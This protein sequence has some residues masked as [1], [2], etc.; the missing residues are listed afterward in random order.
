[1]IITITTLIH[2]SDYRTYRE[3]TKG[4]FCCNKMKEQYDSYFRI[5]SELNILVSGSYNEEEEMVINFCPFCGEKIQIKKGKTL[6]VI[7]ARKKVEVPQIV[8]EYVEVKDDS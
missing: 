7:T 8:T 6:K 5:A 4:D 1:M 2:E 3:E